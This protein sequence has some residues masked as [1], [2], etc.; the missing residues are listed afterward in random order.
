MHYLK[1]TILLLLCICFLGGCTNRM[2]TNIESTPP[3]LTDPSVG[4]QTNAADVEKAEINKLNVDVIENRE[5]ELVFAISIDDFISSYNGYYWQDYNSPYLSPSLEWGRF[6]YDSAIHSDHETY[7]YRFYEY[8]K[9][10]SIPTISVYVPTNS[11]YIQEITLDFDDHGYTEP[12]Y[13]LYEEFCFY[14]LKV[15]FHN[16][17]D[18]KI[19]ELYNNLIN[20]AYNNIVPNEQGYSSNSIPCALYYKDG[21]GLYPYFALGESLHIC[22]IPITSQYLDEFASQGVEIYNIDNDF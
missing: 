9:S 6:T 22:I 16:L 21:I 17:D 8:E 15:F 18:E 1:N 12:L 14:T 13:N 4:E 2:A 5:N 19:T 3:V 7:Y 20:L 11:N 10:W